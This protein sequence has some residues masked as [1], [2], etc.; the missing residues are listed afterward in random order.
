MKGYLLD[1]NHISNAISPG[2]ALMARLGIAAKRGQR[3]GICVPVLCEL[4]SGIRGLVR[5][6]E[7][8]RGLDKFLAHARIW[9]LDRMTA[10]MYGALYQDLRR[11]GRALSQV[12]LMIAALAHQM[13][14]TVL[15]SDRDFAAVSGLSVENWL[16]R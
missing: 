8:R 1:T 10:A 4:E 5:P 12:D 7:H 11:R 15:S 16:E 14:L 3:M 2:S 9:P 6:E 13:D